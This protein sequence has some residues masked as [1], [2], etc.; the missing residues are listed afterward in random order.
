MWT[1]KI[2]GL[3]YIKHPKLEQEF[4]MNPSYGVIIKWHIMGLISVYKLRTMHLL[5]YLQNY[6]LK[7]MEVKW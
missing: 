3:I 1:T 5:E 6:M 4:D 2:N 7:T